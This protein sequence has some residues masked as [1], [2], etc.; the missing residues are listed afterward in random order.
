MEKRL[1]YEVIDLLTLTGR[2][3]LRHGIKRGE[4]KLHQRG[5]KMFILSV[6]MAAL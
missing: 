3:E 1:F 4:K 6:F 5:L 2:Q